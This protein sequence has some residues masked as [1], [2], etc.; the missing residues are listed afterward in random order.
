LARCTAK[1]AAGARCKRQALRGAKRCAQ[2]RDQAS[3]RVAK[4]SRPFT[5][6][7]FRRYARGMVLDTAA[8]WKVEPYFLEVAEEIFAG[9]PEVILDVPEGNAKTTNMA[10]FALYHADHVESAMVPMA[11][12]S[13]D[14][15]GIPFGQ[16]AGF[17]RRSPDLRE[18]FR[19]YEGYRRI[20]ALRTSGRIQVYA[21]DDRTGDGVIPTLAL[22]EELHRHPDL[23][24][25]R[26]WRGKLDKR[27]GQLVGISTA[28]EAGGEYESMKDAAI[29]VAKVSRRGCHTVARTEDF[30]LHQYALRPGENVHDLA[31][32]KRANPFSGITVKGLRRKHGSPTMIES[33]WARF[34]CGVPKRG[35]QSAVGPEEWGALPRTEIPEGEPVWVGLDLGWKWDTTAIVPLWLPEPKRRVLGPAE[36][37]VPPRDGT[38]TSP[39]EIR[40]ALREVHQRNPIHTV[41]LDPNAGGE[42]MAE[43]I[44]APEGI[45][46][47]V[48]AYS[49]TN[50]PQ[51]LAFER[52]MEAIR[53]GWLEHA[54]DE[55]LTRHVLNAIAK[56]VLGGRYRFDRPRTTRQAKGQ[57]QRVIDALSAASAVHAA[58][59][60]EDEPELD[61]SAYR[62]EFI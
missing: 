10:G 29:K 16:A 1:T 27:G 6:D 50:E 37:I 53:E 2:H 3:R 48:V 34:S 42:Q 21:A 24:L 36:V 40:D 11:A 20:E 19:V 14:Q 47:E 56:P 58:A 13:R 59:A 60:V 9:T 49:Q 18:R 57:D 61:R 44:E 8:P 28:G 43:W 39:G 4:R 38:S 35:E 51:A 12:A 32:V 25:Y 15:T 52:W 33:H 41:V 22:L 26:T 46:A 17:V 7:H 45:G 5:V 23:R 54:G 30:V 62:M 31:L 55:A